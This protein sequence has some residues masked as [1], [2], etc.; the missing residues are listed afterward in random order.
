MSEIIFSKKEFQRSDFESFIFLSKFCF[1]WELFQGAL[2]SFFYFIFCRWPTIVANIFIQLPTTKKLPTA[3]SVS[4]SSQ[5]CFE[6]IPFLFW[7][8]IPLTFLNKSNFK[9]F[10]SSL[11]NASYSKLQVKALSRSENNFYQKLFPLAS[12]DI[13]I[14]SN[15][16]LLF[17]AVTV[18]SSVCCY[19]SRSVLFEIFIFAHA[20][21]CTRRKNS[22]TWKKQR[23]L[24]FSYTLVE[25]KRR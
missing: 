19:S 15:T 10:I 25:T 16:F 3:L 20:S 5:I 13:S 17:N 1:F 7:K 23:L 11:F 4:V 2:A 6:A 8:L 12:I 21:F 18:K 24:S 9:G 14:Y 22:S